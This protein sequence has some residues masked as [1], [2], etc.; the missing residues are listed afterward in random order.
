MSN[1]FMLISLRISYNTSFSSWLLLAPTKISTIP[2]MSCDYGVHLGVGLCLLC[3]SKLSVSVYTGFTTRFLSFRYVSCPPILSLSLS[4][5]VC[6]TLHQQDC[7]QLLPDQLLETLQL[8][9]RR[10]CREHAVCVTFHL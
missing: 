6:L 9:C 5:L 4:S 8:Q 2:L 10:F 1:P 7:R 3:L